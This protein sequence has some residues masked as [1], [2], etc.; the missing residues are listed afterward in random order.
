M[1]AEDNLKAGMDPAEAPYAALRSFGGVGSM[2]DR[3]RELRS[4]NLVETTL[5]DI[6]YAVRTL[7]ESPGF[8]TTSVVILA[9]AIGADTVMF[10]VFSAVLLRPLPYL[11][12][13]NPARH[14][15]RAHRGAAAGVTPLI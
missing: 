2:K 1:Q 4:F 7:R 9:L 15:D 10:S 12:L 6:R 8:T 13:P 3:Y 11:L 14:E 5:W